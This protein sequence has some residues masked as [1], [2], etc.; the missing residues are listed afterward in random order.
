MRAL[1]SLVSVPGEAVDIDDSESIRG[2][3]ETYL[4]PALR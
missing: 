4:M 1:V 3:L 2:F